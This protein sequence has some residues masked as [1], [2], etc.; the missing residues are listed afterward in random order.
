MKT[1]SEYLIDIVDD[2]LTDLYHGEYDGCN[3][4]WER[5]MLYDIERHPVFKKI[6][7]YPKTPTETICSMDI[8]NLVKFVDMHRRVARDEAKRTYEN[9]K[10]EYP[11][12]KV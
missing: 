8:L 3:G 5:E 12:Q 4:P 2:M 6:E 9:H 10:A 7:G 1:T 11:V